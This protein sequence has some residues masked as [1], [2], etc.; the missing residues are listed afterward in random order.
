MARAAARATVLQGQLANL[1]GATDV[2]A[3]A[4][5][6]STAAASL[7]ERGDRAGEARAYQVTAGAYARLGQVGAVEEVLD[8]ALA[9]ARVAEDR[10]RTTA[11]LAAA[12]RAALWGPS[13][14]VRASGRCLDV[15]RI[16]RMSPGNRHVEAIALR[17]QA[18]LEAMRGRHQAAREI[19]ATGRAT[20]EELGLAFQLNETAVHAGIVELLAG[21][22]AAAASTSGR[23]FRLRGARRR[24][25]RR[26]ALPRCWPERWSLGGDE[27]AV[28]EA[29][30]QTEYAEAHSGEDLKTVITAT[31]ARAEALARARGRS[32]RR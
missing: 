18:V 6:W 21:D 31:G 29:I 7:A 1:T 8:R 30:D 28:D 13:P 3:T 23:A 4:R 14:V 15:V 25:G 10:R 11:V 22:P 16:L 2:G 17:C 12:P 20:L 5:R 32:R 26:Q 24:G 19:L 27:E 9:A